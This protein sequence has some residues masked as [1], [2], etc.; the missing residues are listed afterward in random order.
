MHVNTLHEE[1]LKFMKDYVIQITTLQKELNE[2][3]HRI[4]LI[5]DSFHDERLFDP[6]NT[7]VNV[8]EV[9]D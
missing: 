1:K 7:N 4:N 2:K 8:D 3:P 9:Y 6:I 5:V